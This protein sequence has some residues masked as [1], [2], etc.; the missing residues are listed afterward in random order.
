MNECHTYDMDNTTDR[1]MNRLVCDNIFS[2]YV[3]T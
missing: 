3:K 1:E 2:F